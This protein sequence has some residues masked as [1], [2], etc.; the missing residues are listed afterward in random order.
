MKRN[1]GTTACHTQHFPWE[2]KF[3]YPL[4]CKSDLY[5]RHSEHSVQMTVAE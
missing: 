4:H 3:R 5:D 1:R 2:G